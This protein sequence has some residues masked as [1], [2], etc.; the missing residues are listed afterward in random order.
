M[1]SGPPPVMLWMSKRAIIIA[2]AIGR[3]SKLLQPEQLFVSKPTSFAFHMSGLRYDED[4][5][6]VHIL[7]PLLNDC[8]LGEQPASKFSRDIMECIMLFLLPSITSLH[9]QTSTRCSNY[10]GNTYPNDSSNVSTD[11]G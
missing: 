4:M 1:P 6:S 8:S 3:K 10:A 2:E 9:R 5:H 7:L 11:Q